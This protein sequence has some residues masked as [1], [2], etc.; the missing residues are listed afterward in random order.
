MRL[1]VGQ[2][3]NPLHEIKD[4]LWR[5]AFLLQHGLNDLGGFRLGE[6]ALAQEAVSVLVGT[7]NDPLARGFDLRNER[8]G[9]RID[10]ARQRG[11]RPGRRRLRRFTL[12]CARAEP[13]AI[14]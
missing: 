1:A 14:L 6:P 11:R 4:A 12:A 2:R 5:T 3:G 9:R 8:G 7:G 13:L 10:E